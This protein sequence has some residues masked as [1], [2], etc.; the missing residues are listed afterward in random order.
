MAPLVENREVLSLTNYTDSH[1]RVFGF[2][3]FKPEDVMGAAKV[4]GHWIVDLRVEDH[5]G[6]L[7]GGSVSW[8]TSN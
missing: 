2:Y 1:H 8:N 6:I 5:L 4:V 7:S 3:F